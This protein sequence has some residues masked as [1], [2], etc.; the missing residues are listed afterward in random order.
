MP[1]PP[2]KSNIVATHGVGAG[3]AIWSACVYRGSDF[4]L[5]DLRFSRPGMFCR[6]QPCRGYEWSYVLE[7]VYM[8]STYL[9][10]QYVERP[11][12]FND[13]A[14]A[15]D[16][17]EDQTDKLHNWEKEWN[18]IDTSRREA[19]FGKMKTKKEQNAAVSATA[20]MLWAVANNKKSFTKIPA[21]SQGVRDFLARFPPFRLL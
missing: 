11:Y 12:V 3:L 19:I 2:K 7:L 13:D 20:G 15:H 10:D 4:C 5:T 21:F 8:I 9:N 17:L 14:Q 18:K 1:P 6:S 16:Y